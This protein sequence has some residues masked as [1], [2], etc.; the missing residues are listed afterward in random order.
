MQK[1]LQAIFV[2][3]QSW[4]HP[5]S[6]PVP[7]HRPSY[8]IP[9]AYEPK[10]LFWRPECSAEQH[11]CPHPL[12]PTNPARVGCDACESVLLYFS[13]AIW[14]QNHFSSLRADCNVRLI[15]RM[16][17]QSSYPP[18][19][20]QYRGQKL[21]PQQ[22]GIAGMSLHYADTCLYDYRSQCKLD[23]TSGC[24]NTAQ[25][26][27]PAQSSSGIRVIHRGMLRAAI[28][29]GQLGSGPVC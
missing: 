5:G 1:W 8:F 4:D 10:R 27:Q 11:P 24:S 22:R 25:R 12:H 15:L 9:A 13:R 28:F 16:A 19:H 29:S 21:W 17:M 6:R 14:P 18:S 3:P 23:N 7:S 2:F 26:G 20:C